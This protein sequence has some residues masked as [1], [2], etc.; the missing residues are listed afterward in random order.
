MIFLFAKESPA[1]LM[2]KGK[3]KEA[4]ASLQ[5]YRGKDYNIQ[6]ELETI[7][8]AAEKAKQTKA[9]FS[10]LKAPHI[11]KPLGISLA[12]M[13]F[14]QVSGINAVL[15]NLNII[16]EKA[17]SSMSPDL[18]SVIIG[19]MQFASTFAASLLMDRAGRKLL[20]IVSSAVMAVSLVALGV[21]FYILDQDETN[22]TNDAESLG[23]LPLV[24]LIIF[25]IA[26][27]IG[28]GPIPWLLMG[29]LFPTEVKELAGSI[30][31]TVNWMSSFIICMT[32]TDMQKSLG[33]HGTYW[34]FAGFCTVALVFCVLLVPETK[35]KT[36][37]EISAMFGA[38]TT[39]K[40]SK[41]S[42]P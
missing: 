39:R 9:G 2:S 25:V 5:H 21:F 6:N 38:P 26:F 4:E 16:F 23:W 14:Q 10:D 7:R 27:S 24:S 37:E 17:G 32:F 42:L 22:G 18:S 20:L 15:F 1:F 36:L 34:L 28:F 31:T 3:T 12:I 19:L 30:A 8:Q 11:L 33:D 13:V 40:D 41:K 35:G 29:E